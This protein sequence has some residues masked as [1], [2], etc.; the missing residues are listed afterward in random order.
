MKSYSI[1]VA[2]VALI[3]LS[4]SFVPR[5]AFAYQAQATDTHGASRATSAADALPRLGMK[6][7]AAENVSL[8]EDFAVY[9]FQKGGVTFVQINRPDGTVLK[10][11]AVAEQGVTSLPI[12]T[13]GASQ[14]MTQS[15]MA[16]VHAAANG[17]GGYKC[18][19]SGDAVYRGTEGA[20]VVVN[21][22]GG[23]IIQMVFMP[24]RV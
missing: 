10:V 19:C 13:L 24:A 11:F 1:V 16:P 5:S 23:K 2:A 6:F 9:K 8:S 20:I 3:V 4:F 17:E 18:P 12:G 7:P 14:V 15:S 21:D 22:K